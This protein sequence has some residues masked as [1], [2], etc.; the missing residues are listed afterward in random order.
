MEKLIGGDEAHGRLLKQTGSTITV[1]MSR[2]SADDRQFVANRLKLADRDARQNSGLSRQTNKRALSLNPTKFLSEAVAWLDGFNTSSRTETKEASAG[3]LIGL[4]G[5]SPLLSE[6]AAKLPENMVYVRASLPFL[7][8]WT[9]RDVSY[10]APVNDNILGTPVVGNSSTVSHVQFELQLNPQAA[11]GVLS[12]IGTTN[13]STVG[14]GGPV[15]VFSNGISQFQSAK[16]VWLD[17]DGI[18]STAAV[19]NAKT[20]LVTTGFDTSLPRLRGR[21]ALRI[22]GNRADATHG[23]AEAVTAEHLSQRV[24]RRF[25]DSTKE[26][27]AALWRVLS[28]QIPALAPDHPLRPRRLHASSFKHMLD[29]LAIGAPGDGSGY[30]PA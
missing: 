3:S 26:E 17:W 13:C 9:E 29:I 28:A 23:M 2:L 21:I 6:S 8:R 22:A 18:H 11:V 25:D 1:S 4:S 10:N 30:V 14:D 27:L 12:L 20:R 16:T 5:F 15:H 24:S 7:R 19:T